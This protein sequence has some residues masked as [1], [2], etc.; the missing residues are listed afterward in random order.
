MHL[1]M[2]LSCF[3]YRYFAHSYGDDTTAP[4]IILSISSRTREPISSRWFLLW[5]YPQVSLISSCQPYRL[6]FF[7]IPLTSR[8]INWSMMHMDISYQATLSNF[9]VNWC[10]LRVFLV[11]HFLVTPLIQLYIL[12]TAKLYS[13]HF[14]TNNPFIIL[15]TEEENLK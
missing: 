15:Y 1:L 11:G 9:I 7:S 12:L 2:V 13:E 14:S 10:H 8:R 6:Y 4:I 3:V 5:S